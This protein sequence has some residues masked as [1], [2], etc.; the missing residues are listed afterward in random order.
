MSIHMPQLHQGE[1]EP[2]DSEKIALNLRLTHAERN[3][4]PVS[5]VGRDEQILGLFKVV[6]TNWQSYKTS[7]STD[8]TKPDLTSLDAMISGA[9]A[10]RD[11]HMNENADE[12]EDESSNADEGS[13]SEEDAA[14]AAKFGPYF[15]RPVPTL[16][17]GERFSFRGTSND[18][19]GMVIYRK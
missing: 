14:A 12:G 5:I 6:V 18:P 16:P 1:N 9:T 17:Q 2:S 8:S 13:E 10:L 7:V 11:L 15:N 19:D 4:G 3:S